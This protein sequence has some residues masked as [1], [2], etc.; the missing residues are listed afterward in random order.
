MALDRDW[1]RDEIVLRLTG[2]N[3]TRR[4]KDYT[5][6]TSVFSQP[7]TFTVHLGEQVSAV[8]ILSKHKPGDP[9][10]LRIQRLTLGET[11]LYDIDEPLQ[12]GRLDA[13]DV[14]DTQE[15]TIEIR[16]RDTIAAL[17]DSYFKQ[18]A[19][20]TEATYYDLT[21][22]QLEAVGFIPASDWLFTGEVGREKAITNKGGGVRLEPKPA[23]EEDRVDEFL[24][25][26]PNSGGTGASMQRVTIPIPK[27]TTPSKDAQGVMV[28]A[29]TGGQPEIT[30][31]TLKARV[32]QQRYAWLKE[33]Y[34]RVGL[35]LWATPAGQF[36][37]STPNSS[38]E[39]AFRLQRLRDGTPGDNNI[40][41]GG[42]R[43]DTVRRY[44]HTLVY[45]RAGGGADGRRRIVGEFVD[46]EMVEWGLIKQI[47][48]EEQDVKT[49]K[50]AD[51]LARRYGLEA[52]RSSRSLV[53]TVPGHTAPSLI[54]P[55]QSF[56]YYV[57]T[58]AHV[59]DQKYGID[60]V[61]Y[62]SEVEFRRQ[63]QSTSVI[64]L[65]WPEDLDFAEGDPKR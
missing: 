54:Q 53:Y 24:V 55:G 16:G 38:Q 10:E 35:F 50:A 36:I 46:E 43:N 49:Q 15:T 60:G 52:R 47:S 41:S 61:Y 1:Q 8:D 13:V 4:C 32:G 26:K 29:A 48:Y 64:T 23:A 57:N 34:K 28:E 27:A 12:T 42:R 2:Q 6:K 9:F 19:A 25:W 20:F 63:P 40:L 17:F 51:T 21:V 44:S 18:E 31:K 33:Q 30:L 56:P 62:V 65:L 11:S 37:L 59:V 5:V 39:P 45:G 58:M 14:P 22:K 7:C 3:V